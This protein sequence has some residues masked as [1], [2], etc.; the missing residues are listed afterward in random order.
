MQGTL[1]TVLA[2]MSSKT[3]QKICDSEKIFDERHQPFAD[4]IGMG[5]GLSAGTLH[6]LTTVMCKIVQP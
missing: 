5:A 4:I 3:T 6:H 1:A 2:S